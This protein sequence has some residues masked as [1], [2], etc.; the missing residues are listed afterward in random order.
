MD[1]MDEMKEYEVMQNLY[2]LAHLMQRNR[3]LKKEN[4]ILKLKAARYKAL[5]HGKNE[6]ADKLEKQIKENE[7]NI[8]GECRRYG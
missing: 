5:F 8:T 6:L 3:N 1:E 7:E 4:A 2:R